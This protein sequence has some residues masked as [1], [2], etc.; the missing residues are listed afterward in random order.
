MRSRE[1]GA[2]ARS[3]SWTAVHGD[4]IWLC[5]LERL[6]FVCGVLLLSV[7]LSACAYRSHFQAEQERIFRAELERGLV[8]E[9]EHDQSEWSPERVRRYEERR[10]TSITR[11]ARLGRLEIPSLDLSVMLLDG[12]DDETLDRA[13]GHIEGTAL[14]GRP[15]NL[16]IAGHRDGF[17]R[18]L[19][20]LELGDELML[21]TLDGVAHYQVV[22]F[23]IVDPDRVDVL[24]PGDGTSM[25]LVTCYP[26]YYVG[27]AP[28]RFIVRADQRSFAAW[29]DTGTR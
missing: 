13:V 1:H 18:G 24:L 7:Y 10:G 3:R 11:V 26:F 5:G 2:G 22:E 16:G 4:A 28:Q 23:S 27:D 25:T 12:T 20:H 15:G 6:L 19:R 21:T 29:K 17:F 9:E 14:P 8:A